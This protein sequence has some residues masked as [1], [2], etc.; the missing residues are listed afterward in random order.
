VHEFFGIL[1]FKALGLRVVEDL[2]DLLL[3][4]RFMVGL[5]SPVCPLMN[6]SISS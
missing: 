1:P 4:R 5:L 6:C 2:A 3:A